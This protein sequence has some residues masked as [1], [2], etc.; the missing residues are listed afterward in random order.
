[1]AGNRRDFLKTLGV[2]TATTACAGSASAYS[3]SG[4][5]AAAVDGVGVLVDTT[6]CVG[7]RLCEYAC[8]QS[9][10]LPCESLES[11]SDMSVFKEMRRPSPVSLTVINEWKPAD[12]GKP[13]YAKVNCMHCN[14]PA[15]VSACIVGAMEKQPGGQVTYDA[16]KCIGCR[17]CMEACPFQIPA[18]EY[19]NAFSPQIRKCQLCFQERTSKGKVP[20]CVEACPREALVFGKR[21]E[22]LQLAHETI[23]KHPGEYVN[24]V[25]GEKE[26]GGTA[27]MYLSRVPFEELSF[28]KLGNEPV[29]STTEAIQH[30]LFRVG[31]AP[32]GLFA[33]LGATMIATRP[34]VKKARR[35]KAAVAEETE[36]VKTAEVD[37]GSTPAV[38]PVVAPEKIAYES[39]AEHDE[40][41]QPVDRKVFTPGVILLIAIMLVGIGAYLYRFA[42]GLASV[43]HLDQQHPWGLW[44]GIDVASGVA[45]AAGGFA[46]VAMSRVLG[47]RRFEP[48]VRPALLTAML[49]YT[50][51]VTGLL[52]D[53]GRYYNVWHPLMPW[54]WQG[55]SVLFAVGICEV[56]C[57]NLLYLIFA[58]VLLE[59]LAAET[60]R[61]PR[62]SRM[63]ALAIPVMNRVNAVLIIVGLIAALLHQSALGNLLVLTPYKLN[64]LW[65]TPILSALFLVSAIGGGGLAMMCWES[66]FASW[67]LKIKPEMHL[68]SPLAKGVAAI[69][70][71]YLVAKLG[72][73]AIRGVYREL[74]HV[75]LFTICWFVEV[76]VG[77]AA[78]V[79]MLLIPRVRKSPVGL[80]IASTLIVAGIVF[81]RLNIF[82]IAYRPPYGKLYI[83]SF[84]EFAITIGLIAFLMLGYRLVVTYFPVIS[85]P[86]KEVAG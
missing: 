52:A 67:S 61:F 75:N 9:N 19:D 21:A 26:V 37:E 86:R 18:Y 58:P 71:I 79:L 70:G 31:A 25:Y 81:N 36:S 24:H 34:R 77:I 3:E 28:V 73:V 33:T 23:A 13:V 41:P 50:A 80:F 1:M 57:I 22:L 47:M 46:A 63:A 76:V 62:L 68:L 29:I 51:V 8:K 43:T 60:K 82:V 17:Y 27:W 64:A 78:P 84:G 69:M 39:H 44:V 85:Q 14:R 56:M 54:M 72:D 59:R 35:V 32:F 83:P 7:C 53:L 20:A 16:D 40:V 2:I 4:H 49:G 48:L 74:A 12:G 15:C 45:L 5:A 30:A 11:F 66:L 55:N 6:L 10:H 38:E 65:H 42:F